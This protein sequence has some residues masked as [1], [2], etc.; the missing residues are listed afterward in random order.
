LGDDRTISL[1]QYRETSLGPSNPG[2]PS[3][4]QV[5]TGSFEELR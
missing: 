5:S 1:E 2:S 4:V 3:H